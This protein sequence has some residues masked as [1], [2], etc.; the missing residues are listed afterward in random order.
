MDTPP[1]LP[2]LPGSEDSPKDGKL[3][4]SPAAATS[5]VA[6]EP[7][8]AGKKP[9]KAKRQKEPRPPRARNTTAWAVSALAG[10]VALAAG[11][12]GVQA[13]FAPEPS[14]AVIVTT[15]EIRAN[16]PLVA[17]KLAVAEWPAG[18][19][20][21]E[22]LT[23]A[24]LEAQTYF[25]K[26]NLP[27]GEPIT[28]TIAQTATRTSTD[29]PEGYV[30]AS[31][32]V[33]PENAA[34]G[35]VQAGSFVD[36]LVAV[37][38]GESVVALSNIYILDAQSAADPGSSSVDAENQP[39]P[40]S[41]ALYG[42]IPTL[43]TVAVTE[44]QAKV[45]NSVKDLGLYLVLLPV[46]PGSPVG[47]LPQPEADALIQPSSAPKPEPTPEAKPAQPEPTPSVE[48]TPAAAADDTTGR[49]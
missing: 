18:L 29:V 11:A 12:V 14:V 28:K 13:Y 16:E 21:P 34:A 48:P 9:K 33:A 45:L 4:L 47:P 35:K 5:V 32:K 41:P 49:P 26:V 20:P 23:V 6:E 22:A 42:G 8:A 17:D 36:I 15:A 7:P 40:N 2:P 1:P 39:G 27:A 10:I 43:Y 38:S 24:D 46:K 25:A 30:V 31:F 44:A 19:T 37:D 3:F